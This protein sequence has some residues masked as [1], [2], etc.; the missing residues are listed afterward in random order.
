M[1]TEKKQKNRVLVPWVGE[2]EPEWITTCKAD[3]SFL[4]LPLCTCKKKYS[5]Q[6]AN[7]IFVEIAQYE[8]AVFLDEPSVDAF[9]EAFFQ[10]FDDARCLGGLRIACLGE[11]TANAVREQRYAVDLEMEESLGQTLVETGSLDSAK[12]LVISGNEEEE[13]LLKLLEKEGMA[14]VDRFPVYQKK[15]T[16]LKSNSVAKDFRK[17]GADIVLFPDVDS[18]GAFMQ[19]AVELVGDGNELSTKSLAMDSGVAEAMRRRKIPVDGTLDG[20]WGLLL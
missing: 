10:K 3:A 13:A 7:D 8:W 11:A 5:K 19:Q 6:T 16:A 20:D 9:F 17:N 15:W 1:S 12:V 4:S 2:S 14:I 18:V